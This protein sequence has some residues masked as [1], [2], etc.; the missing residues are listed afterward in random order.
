LERES[1]TGGE[2]RERRELKKL[3]NLEKS[4]GDA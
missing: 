1:E 3:R 4:K 2:K